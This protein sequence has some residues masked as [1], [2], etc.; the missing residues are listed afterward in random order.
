MKAQSIREIVS[1]DDLPPEVTAGVKQF[2]ALYTFTAG[3]LAL[4][5]Y[6]NMAEEVGYGLALVYLAIAVVFLVG[7]SAVAVRCLDELARRKGGAS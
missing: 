4:T 3:M 7:V 1:R 5:V 6:V 2:R